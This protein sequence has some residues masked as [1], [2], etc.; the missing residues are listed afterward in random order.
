MIRDLIGVYFP[1]FGVGEMPPNSK[2][3]LTGLERANDSI[4]RMPRDGEVLI[5]VMPFH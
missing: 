4:S 1:N 3:S 5:V 2:T